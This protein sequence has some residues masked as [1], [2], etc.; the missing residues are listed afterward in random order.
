MCDDCEKHM[1]NVSELRELG[2]DEDV[3]ASA[4]H[5]QEM[6]VHCAELDPTVA[7]ETLERCLRLLRMQLAAEPCERAGRRWLLLFKRA[8]CPVGARYLGQQ[9]RTCRARQ[10]LS[11][12]LA[13]EV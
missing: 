6:G 11:N 5:I 13:R 1:L 10:E 3:I 9:C 4:V 8:L 7:Q 2:F 12:E